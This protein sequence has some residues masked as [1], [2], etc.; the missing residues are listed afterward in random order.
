MMPEMTLK[1]LIEFC[2]CQNWEDLNPC[3]VFDWLKFP[4]SK[5]NCDG[6]CAKCLLE[7]SGWDDI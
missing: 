4:K 2:I 5:G 7:A 1:E 6:D 3:E